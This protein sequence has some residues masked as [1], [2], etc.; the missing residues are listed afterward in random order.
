MIAESEPVRW[1]ATHLLP[2]ATAA[3]EPAPGTRP[4]FTSLENH[5]R[6]D[7][8]TIPPKVDEKRWRLKITG[9]V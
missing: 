9:L 5:Y 3:V 8:N 6:I 2:N 1:S 4:E 7:I